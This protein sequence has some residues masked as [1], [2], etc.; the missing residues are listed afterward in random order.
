MVPLVQRLYVPS[1]RVFL[2]LIRRS[3]T[4][5]F[6]NNMG[7]AKGLP[8]NF[9]VGGNFNST[10]DFYDFYFFDVPAF[11]GV[12]VQLRNIPAGSNYDLYV[13]GSAKLLWGSSVNAGNLEETVN[14]S[15]S[16][17]RYYVLV[18]RLYGPSE[19]SGYQLAVL[20]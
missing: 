14:L 20:R 7:A 18:R 10:Y 15:L 4:S 19:G 3:G 11:S 6:D 13:F 5:D 2:P 8:F 17:G 16:P 12:S 9:W 1:E